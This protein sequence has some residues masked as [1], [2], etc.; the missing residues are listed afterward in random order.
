MHSLGGMPSHDHHI[1]FAPH[2]EHHATHG[3]AAGP[4][5]ILVGLL[6]FFTSIGWRWVVI[7]LLFLILR[8]I[9]IVT[10]AGLVTG[11]LCAAIDRA[12]GPPQPMTM[13]FCFLVPFFAT[14][15]LVT[16]RTRHVRPRHVPAIKR[17][18]R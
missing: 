9:Y 12:Y 14:A 17:L 18:M 6:V 7:P 10:W 8:P 5:W 1:A 11:F 16:R 15:A 4:L 2:H 13:A 3:S